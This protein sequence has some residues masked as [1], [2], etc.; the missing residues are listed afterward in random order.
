MLSGEKQPYR[1]IKKQDGLG[2]LSE[3]PVFLPEFSRWISAPEFGNTKGSIMISNYDF[4]HIK[5][6]EFVERLSKVENQLG[7]LVR[8]LAFNL[9]GVLNWSISSDGKVCYG[10]GSETLRKALDQGELGVITVTTCGEF[11]GSDHQRAFLLVIG[12]YCKSRTN[13]I[14]FVQDREIRLY[15]SSFPVSSGWIRALFSPFIDEDK[16]PFS[17]LS[18]ELVHPRLRIWRPTVSTSLGIPIKGVIGRYQYQSG[19]DAQIGAAVA[20]TKWYTPRYYKIDTNW[21]GEY[22]KDQDVSD[23]LFD[24]IEDNSKIVK[25]PTELLNECIVSLTNPVPSFNDI[26]SKNVKG[27][28]LP[29]IKHLEVEMIGHTVMYWV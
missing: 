5:H 21:P 16:F 14:T 15:L 3:C 12:G 1:K 17:M 26:E 8:Y 10:R 7:S 4:D 11:R 22:I 18:Y 27:F 9:E 2:L 13:K 19:Y 20:D 6:N 25:C 23:R 24:T 29:L 28:R